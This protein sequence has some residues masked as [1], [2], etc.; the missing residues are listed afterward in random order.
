MNNN[1]KEPIEQPHTDIT[2]EQRPA[3]TAPRTR[4]TRTARAWL[5]ALAFGLG[6]G[7]T[8]CL[9]DPNAGDEGIESAD[10][11]GEEV[12][13]TSSALMNQQGAAAG[14]KCQVTAGPYTGK[15][16]KYDADGWCCF[17]TTTQNV[18]VD[19]AGGRCKDIKLTFNPAVITGEMTT[20]TS[21]LAP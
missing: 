17:T 7:A 16:G 21:S 18:C 5:L 19:C 20:A 2:T 4:G 12:V 3:G 6:L 9:G 14:G 8:A 1:D 11:Q 15:K 13:Q 10:A